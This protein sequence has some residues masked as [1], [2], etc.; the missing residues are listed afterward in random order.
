MVQTAHRPAAR[1]LATPTRSNSSS[2]AHCYTLRPPP[3]AAAVPSPVLPSACAPKRLCS[4]APESGVSHSHPLS[5][6]HSTALVTRLTRNKSHLRSRLIGDNLHRRRSSGYR[7]PHLRSL[8]PPPRPR[9]HPRPLRPRLRLRPPAPARALA[10]SPPLLLP[11]L[12]SRPLCPPLCPWSGGLSLSRPLRQPPQQPAA[13]L[14][15]RLLLRWQAPIFLPLQRQLADRRVM[16][17]VAHLDRDDE[18]AVRIE[19]FYSWMD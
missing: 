16:D 10:A 1:Q 12:P 15:R 6:S 2:A 18:C 3:P 7:I 19:R 9:P 14:L 11:L 4:Q 17:L 8:R 13:A 5:L